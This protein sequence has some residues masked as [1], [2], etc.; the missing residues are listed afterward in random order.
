MKTKIINHHYNPDENDRCYDCGID[1]FNE[2]IDEMKKRHAWNH[3]NFKNQHG[4]IAN[5]KGENIQD[6]FDTRDKNFLIKEKEQNPVRNEFDIKDSSGVVILTT[7]DIDNL[8]L[9]DE[10]TDFRKEKIFSILIGIILALL[11]AKFAWWVTG[12]IV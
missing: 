12:L 9:V 8:F 7:K 1:Q 6:I 5:S 4:Y 2:S 11:I 10:Y 3:I